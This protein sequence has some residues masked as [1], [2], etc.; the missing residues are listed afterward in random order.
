MRTEFDI[1]VFIIIAAS[2]TAQ[3]LIC[4]S[5]SFQMTFERMHILIF[6]TCPFRIIVCCE[7]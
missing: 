7:Q 4:Q 6:V 5:F 2:Y 3:W 1:N